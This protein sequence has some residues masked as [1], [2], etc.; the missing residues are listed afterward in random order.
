[1]KSLTQIF[2]S[3]IQIKGEIE[4]FIQSVFALFQGMS[5]IFDECMSYL[6]LIYLSL[7]IRVLF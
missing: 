5:M 2:F 6:I 3:S 7:A 1:M 4:E